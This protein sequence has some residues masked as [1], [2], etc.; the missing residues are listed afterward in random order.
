MCFY[1]VPLVHVLA[2]LETEKA[3]IDDISGL[4]AGSCQKW[5]MARVPLLKNMLPVF[6]QIRLKCN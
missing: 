5:L 4:H 6:H 2:L 1:S 3:F